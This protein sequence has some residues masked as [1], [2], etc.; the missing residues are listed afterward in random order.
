MLR[1]FFLMKNGV[2]MQIL[3]ITDN[4]KMSKDLTRFLETS[5]LCLK[6]IHL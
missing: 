1:F 6:Y 3:T 4:C 2:E 5:Y